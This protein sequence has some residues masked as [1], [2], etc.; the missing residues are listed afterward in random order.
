[1]TVEDSAEGLIKYENG[2][3]LSFFAMNNYLINEPIEIRLY[4]ENGTAKLS[5]TEAEIGADLILF[6]KSVKKGKIKYLKELVLTSEK[7]AVNSAISVYIAKKDEDL[8]SLSK[9]LNVTPEELSVTNPELS[10]PLTGKE[11]IIIFRG[12]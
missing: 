12:K 2:V 8:W 1:M 5:Y 11:R 10:F 6:V 4:C 7:T 9:R 3:L